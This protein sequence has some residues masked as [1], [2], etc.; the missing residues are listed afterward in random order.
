LNPADRI[1]GIFWFP[2]AG[3]NG[4]PTAAASAEQF[5]MA[6]TCYKRSNTIV[7]WMRSPPPI[8]LLPDDAVVMVWSR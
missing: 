3:P 8:P 7:A 1:R 6:W 5:A 4:D 2:E